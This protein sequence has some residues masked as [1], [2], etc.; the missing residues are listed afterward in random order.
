MVKPEDAQSLACS[1]ELL[2]RQQKLTAS[3]VKVPL[4]THKNMWNV[5]LSVQLSVLL[6]L[7]R[8]LKGHQLQMLPTGW[9][10]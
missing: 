4:K 1:A 2:I 9:S 8:N 5:I 10:R 7:D 6:L 3:V